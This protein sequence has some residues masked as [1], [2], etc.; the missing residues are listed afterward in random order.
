MSFSTK[1]FE[2]SEEYEE[3]E[4]YEESEYKTCTFTDYDNM[5][6]ILKYTDNPKLDKITNIINALTK[7]NFSEYKEVSFKFD[8][9]YG[10]Y[11]E[12]LDAAKLFNETAI[13]Y[14][15]L[16]DEDAIVCIQQK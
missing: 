3:Y 10:Y 15:I 2:D 11:N 6:S 16:I 13:E 7:T 8:F 9:N 14:R 4:E 1:H 12:W 5:I